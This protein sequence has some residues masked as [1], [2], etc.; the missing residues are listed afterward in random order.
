MINYP[1]IETI[2]SQTLRGK[3]RWLIKSSTPVHRTKRSLIYAIML[4]VCLAAWLAMT[5]RDG[6]RATSF[7]TVGRCPDGD[8]CRRNWITDLG[9][10]D[11]K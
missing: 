1:K 3:F 6:C 4:G 8:F 11:V 9:L 7:G 5:A 10:C 2:N